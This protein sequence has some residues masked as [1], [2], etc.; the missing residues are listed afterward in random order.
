MSEQTEA[1]NDD[2]DNNASTY[3]DAD[4]RMMDENEDGD[5]NDMGHDED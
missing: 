1:Q 2:T 3:I 4:Q 5:G